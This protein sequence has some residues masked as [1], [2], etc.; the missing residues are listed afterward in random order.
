[1]RVPPR[2]LLAEGTCVPLKTDASRHA[3]PFRGLRLTCVDKARSRPTHP[4]RRSE[5]LSE[6]R[7]T[8]RERGNSFLSRGSSKPSRRQCQLQ[9]T[10]QTRQLPL[11]HWSEESVSEI[12]R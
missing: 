8:N 2:E 9:S 6:S 11:R 1:M 5:E 4:S 12:R 3:T 10:R 7:R